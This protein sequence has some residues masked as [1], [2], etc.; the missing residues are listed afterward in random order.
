MPEP[1]SEVSAFFTIEQEVY[2]IVWRD[3][4]NKM[5]GMRYDRY[6]K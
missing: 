4:M 5:K 3:T 1:E 6:D 2:G